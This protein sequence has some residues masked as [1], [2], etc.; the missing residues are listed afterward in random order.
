MKTIWNYL[1]PKVPAMCVGFTIKFSG[2]IVELLLPWM[3]SVIL[4]QFVVQR[5]LHSIVIWGSLMILCSAVALTTNVVA[6]RMAARVSRDFI[7]EVRQDLFTKTTEIS[8]AQ[9]D[10][11]TIPS[12][13][14]RMS[15][16][17]YNLHMMV[18]RMQRLGVRAPILL[19]G[20]IAITLS[21][22]PVLTLVLIAILPILGFIV[23]YISRKGV[24]LYSKTQT[25]LD[26][27][28]RR[29][30]ESITGI[31]VIQALSK[32]E[33]EKNEF[34]KANVDV[35]NNDYRASMLM[36]ITNPTMNFLLNIGLTLV[37]VIGA[38]RVNNGQTNPG[39]IVAF[40]SYF[41]IILNA[42][43]MVTRM[44]VMYSKGIASGRRIAQV[45][46]TP[47]EMT[48]RDLPCDDAPVHIRFDN[49]SFSYAKVNENLK[50]ISFS[51]KQGET[52]G[53]IGATGS[54]KTT[55][56]QLLLRFYDADQGSIYIGNQ[57]IQSI[58]DAKLHTM[59]GVV[60]QND[61]LYSDTIFEN[62]DFGRNLS[63]DQI[64]QAAK[65]AQADFI[66]E[67]QEGFS[68][69]I[70]AKGADISGGQKQRLLIARALAANPQIMILDDSSSALD[71]KTDAALRFALKSSFAEAT[72]IIIAQRISSI[73][74]ADHILV[75][76]DGA[77]IGY[78]THDELMEQC[79]EYR[80]IAAFQMEEVG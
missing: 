17:T 19:V 35:A 15:S 3:L 21:M 48:Q 12:L 77:M 37:I 80:D 66:D 41:T 73:H 63:P 18:D 8:C 44:F 53:I 79:S 33:Y 67:R 55:L 58:S 54:G 52:L 39:T 75:L 74:S 27:M 28:I 6:N 10:Q 1:R 14:S 45:L 20:G 42:L 51:L 38:Y 22:E 69:E 65:V 40:L 30:Q 26:H 23:V 32:T 71:Y 13:V 25:S 9:T 72:K 5:D 49:V 61:F 78:G 4:D 31:R 64:K 2:T 47:E 46:D 11:F 62:I 59:F 50:D 56:I 70:A 7:R 68:G 43:M 76:D 57:N 36:S 24:V 16:D 29:A 34:N 60:F